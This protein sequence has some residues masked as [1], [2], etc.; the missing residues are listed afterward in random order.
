M[1]VKTYRGQ[2]ADGGQDIIPLSTKDGSVGYRIKKFQIISKSPSTLT[3][4]STIKIYKT[5]QTTV[6]GIIDFSDGDLLA[7]AFWSSNS[8]ATYYADDMTVIFDSELFNQDIYITHDEQAGNAPC[9][10]YLELEQVKL[11]QTQNMSVT[12]KA[13]RGI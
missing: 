12:L 10:Y 9:N 1:V 5:K 8:G 2:L 7:V 6:T 11:D 13:I 3:N 4:E